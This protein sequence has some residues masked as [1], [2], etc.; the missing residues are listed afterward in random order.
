[1]AILRQAARKGADVRQVSRCEKAQENHDKEGKQMNAASGQCVRLPPKGIV[2][3]G[4]YRKV[5]EVP[6]QWVVPQGLAFEMLEPCEGK[7]LCMVRGK[8]AAGPLTYPVRSLVRF[9]S[10]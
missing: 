4:V 6:H 8:G 7:L 2:A 10:L 1:M 5:D 9:A 3:V